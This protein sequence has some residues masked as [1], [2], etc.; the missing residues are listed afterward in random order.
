MGVLMFITCVVLILA[1]WMP[2]LFLLGLIITAGY[3]F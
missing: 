3:F 1:F 2:G